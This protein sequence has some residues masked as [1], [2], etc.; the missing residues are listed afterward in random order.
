MRDSDII[1]VRNYEIREM[2][3]IVYKKAMSLGKKSKDAKIDAYT[4]IE[5]RY[6]ISSERARRIVNARIKY[7]T[8]RLNILFKERTEQLIDLL[9]EVS[10]EICRKPS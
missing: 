5:L 3:F 9:K 8:A 1:E 7:N 6:C 4:A 2:Y 10:D